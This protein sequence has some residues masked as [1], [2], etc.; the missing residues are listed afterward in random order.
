[1][2]RSSKIFQRVANSVLSLTLAVGLAPAFTTAAFADDAT[3]VDI[4]EGA[5]LTYGSQAFNF[6]D[7]D[8]EGVSALST[9]DYPTTYDLRNKGVVTSVKNQTPYTTC[10]AFASLA[11]AETSILS[12]TG[13]TAASSKIDLS[14]HHLAWFAK[15]HV[16]VEGEDGYDA[17]N[18][19]SG[20]G[21]YVVNA[22]TQRMNYGIFYMATN[23]FASGM[24]PV[25]ES[26][27]PLFVYHGKNALVD[28]YKLVDGTRIW[29]DPSLTYDESVKQGY[30]PYCY[31]SEDDWSIDYTYRNQQ[32]YE[33]EESYILP[34][35]YSDTAKTQ[36]V[37]ASVDAVKAQLTA[38]RGVAAS[39]YADTAAPT[40][41]PSSD[42]AQFINTKT[43]AHYTWTPMTINHAVCIVGW[44][45]NYS[46][47]NFLTEV[48]VLDEDGNVVLNEDGTP[49]TKTVEQP[50]GDGAWIV[51]NSWGSGSGDF[52][53]YG[54]WGIDE[55]SDGKGDGYFYLSYYDKSIGNLEAFD[56]YT[57]DYWTD[58]D[59]Y[60]VEQYDNAPSNAAGSL[61]LTTDTYMANVFTAEAQSALRSI[62]C[63][64][65]TPNTKVTYSVYLV[66]E[67]TKSTPSDGKLV[68]SGTASYALGGFHHIELDQPV[69]MDEGQSYAVVERLTIVS[70]GVEKAQFVLPIAMN[71]KVPNC[72]TYTK[73][74]VNKGESL[75]GTVTDGKWVWQDWTDV[76][77]DLHKNGQL[78]EYWDSDN[79]PIKAY[80]EPAATLT[81]D[82]NGGSGTMDSR[83][84]MTGTAITLPECSFTAPA[85]KV[86]AGWEYDGKTYAAGDE[87]AFSADVTLTAQWRTTFP[88]VSDSSAWYF[89]AVYKSVDLGLF[90]G[91]SDGTFAPNGTLTRGQLAVI[92]WRYLDP[93]EAKAYVQSEAKNATGMADV[94]DAAYYTGAANWAVKN[95][96]ITGKDSGTRFDPNGQVTAEQLCSILYKAMK[97]KAPE[98]TKMIDALADGSSI[99]S[100]AKSACEWA[101]ENGVLSGYNNADGTKS[102]RPQEGVSRARTATILVNAIE[103]EVLVAE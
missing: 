85:G 4:L 23:A 58:S 22:T 16:P 19:Q 60:Y 87:V 62:S 15:T 71:D 10:W 98:G 99:S 69:Y 74:V 30:T 95:G 1:M 89:K 37:Q 11:A 49:Q 32:S 88:D 66:D 46:K 26:V 24:G 36:F 52:P 31:S 64:T 75:C 44:D 33:L 91:N 70:D 103:N 14:E 83:Q 93:D 38:G 55:N 73:M 21:F 96:V 100:W 2:R 78:T 41:D 80:L 90:K 47:D 59:T 61:N 7:G 9:I 94:A 68:A 102:L 97:A 92:L 6:A 65:A 53:N 67:K 43:W 18:T 3:T 12:E 45:D 56:F 34:T 42:K 20:E 81:F 28:A 35:N 101:L 8:D 86:F 72:T 50:A 5:T 77:V 82:A 79:Y 27:N 76:L 84:V 63:Y 13:Q 48:N 39:Y 54:D 40:T 29:L 17:S 25:A 51:K 57:S